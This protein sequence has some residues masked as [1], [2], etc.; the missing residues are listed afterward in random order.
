M[1]S[2]F[3]IT[4]VTPDYSNKQIV[5]QT[6]FRVDKDTV[7]KKNVSVT[8]AE[9]GI[10]VVYKLS[11]DE[12][13][14]IITLKDWPDLDSYYVVKVTKIK[15][16]LNRDLIHPLSKDI[17]F[18]P[19]TALKC[20]IESPKNNEAVKEQHKLVYFS[21]KQVN[22]DGTMVSHPMP[23]PINPELPPKD[24]EDSEL[25]SK[26]AVLEDESDI[27][28][29]FEF[30]SDTAFFDIVKDY[31]SN[32]TDG[33]ITLDNAQYFMRARVIE[34]G[35]QGDWSEVITFTVI[36][37]TACDVELEQA[38]QDYLD[39]IFAPVDFFVNGFEEPFEIVS[40]SENGK[41]FPEFFIEF[42]KDIDVSKLPE[43]LI[44]YRRDL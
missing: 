23:Y 21:I 43:T 30:A 37:E 40:Q 18:K 9:S 5:I 16:M 17:Y 6:T 2:I 8:S 28:Y 7:N 3:N 25:A 27:M 44:A 12:D 35:L 11:V 32:Y 42:S 41:T 31:K 26:E 34:N 13:R 38:K 22:S 14:I 39:D 19:E 10:T 33:Y 15:D 29:H 1:Q 4:S 36:P 24:E 20:I